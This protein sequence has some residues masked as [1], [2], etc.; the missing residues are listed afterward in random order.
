MAPAED[1]DDDIRVIFS[2]PASAAG[3]D[4]SLTLSP[5]KKHGVSVTDGQ[6]LVESGLPTSGANAATG[7]DPFEEDD[8]SYFERRSISS[9]VTDIYDRHAIP[10]QFKA[11][12]PSNPQSD[13]WLTQKWYVIR[14]GLE[15]GIFYEFWCVLE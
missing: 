2:L 1:G 4:L 5:R 12:Y 11:L 15:I 6:P 14:R 7:D 3:H 9:D 8:T 10:E 13:G